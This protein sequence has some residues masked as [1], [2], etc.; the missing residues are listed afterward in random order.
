MGEKFLR[1]DTFVRGLRVTVVPSN[2]T[3]V[4][5]T[6]PTMRKTDNPFIGRV[7]K[8]SVVE[9]RVCGDYEGE[10]NERR[11]AEGKEAD[12]KAKPLAWGRR[13]LSEGGLGTPLIEH[14]DQLY[15]QCQVVGVGS[16]T[17]LVDGRPASVGELAEI[18]GFMSE[19]EDGG[20]Q[21]VD[22]VVVV[23]TFKLASIVALVVGGRSVPLV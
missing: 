21:G 17:F 7:V 2:L 18:G 9:V 10:V 4:L 12:F 8:H 22:D 5:E 23:R 1:R 11:L 20:G 3:L 6:R 19:R 15:L 14:K 16:V 13:V